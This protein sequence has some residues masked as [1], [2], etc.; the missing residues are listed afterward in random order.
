MHFEQATPPP[1]TAS[2]RECPTF[3]GLLLAAFSPL[4]G[5]IFIFLLNKEF[6]ILKKIERNWYFEGI[7]FLSTKVMSINKKY[8]L[9]LKYYLVLEAFESNVSKLDGTCSDI[10]FILWALCH[11]PPGGNMLTTVWKNTSLYIQALN[12]YSY[13]GLIS[14]NKRTC[15]S[16]Y[17]VALWEA[18]L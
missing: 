5:R 15:M 14:F 6:D 1:H 4:F 12:W 18:L 3:S 8:T 10:E 11:I 7:I 17:S 9:I 2:L 13:F 16:L